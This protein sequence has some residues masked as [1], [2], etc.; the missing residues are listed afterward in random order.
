MIKRLCLTLLLAVGSPSLTFAQS[1]TLTPWPY[2]QLVDNSGVAVNN[3]CIWTYQSGTTTPVTTYSDT[4]GTPNLNPVRTDTAGRSTLAVYLISGQNYK[5]VYENNDCAPP[6]HGTV[7]RTQDNI[8]ATPSSSANVDIS[9]VAGENISAGQCAYLSDGSGSKNAG[10]WYKCDAGNT[11]S[12]VMP[13]VG[14][15]PAAIA[16]GATGSIRISGSVGGLAGLS[17]GSVYYA[18][19]AGALTSS[20]PALARAVGISDTT[21]SLVVSSNPAQRLFTLGFADDF[22][23]TLTSGTCVTSSDV[24]AATTIYLT[25]CTGNRL[26]LFDG[27]GV[28]STY[29]T[30]EISVSVPASTSQMYDVFAFSNSGTPAIEVLAW[31]NDTTRATA[32]VRTNG[33]WTK[34]GDS[35]R[36]YLGSFRTTGSS[37]QTEDSLTKRYLWNYYNRVPRPMR[38]LEST[39][40][41]NYTTFSFQQANAAAANQLD[42]VVG[43][44]E[45]EIS[46][47]VIGEFSNATG[48]ASSYGAVAI[49]QDSTTTPATGCVF[50]LVAS[51]I[52]GAAVGLVSVLET[53]PPIGRHTY[54]WLEEAGAT[55]TG[56]FYGT[57]AG[58]TGISATW[59]N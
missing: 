18:G 8:L 29:T 24:T 35:T 49:G 57:N 44:A 40:S 17:S 27:A 31:T 32:L 19:S 4:A 11:Y 56:T 39:A 58:Q 3:G 10:Q 23:L 6:A 37:G 28:P 7:I 12:S 43:V 38:R 47:K 51:T 55:G 33:R 2:L 15:A 1:Y 52:N 46:V 20:A 26:T 59:R 50:T 45:D 22:R 42:L 25:P 14:L 34:S 53:V 16:S 30:A 13:E 5:F 48:G 41:W 54:V 9:G 21:S 36:L